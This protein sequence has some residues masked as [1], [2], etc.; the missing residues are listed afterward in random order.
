ME[1]QIRHP[2]HPNKNVNYRLKSIYDLESLAQSEQFDMHL[3]VIH[4][5][6]LILTGRHNTLAKSQYR[7]SVSV[8][9]L[10]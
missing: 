3:I 6:F 7:Q 5:L 2:T 4:G 1:P 9:D 8:S 10:I